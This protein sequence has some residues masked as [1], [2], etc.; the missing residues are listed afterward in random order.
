M[1]ASTHHAA[2]RAC[3]RSRAAAAATTLGVAAVAAALLSC[4]A[5]ATAFAATIT[6]RVV[7]TGGTPIPFVRIR[8]TG[9]NAVPYS[10]TA[11]TTADGT[12]RLDYPQAQ[13]KTLT[14]EP[15]RIDRFDGKDAKVPPH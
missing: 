7:D 1:S 12:F 8:A 3:I 2:R 5:P 10:V 9:R 11:F 15:F 13:A 4:V 6:G 14:I